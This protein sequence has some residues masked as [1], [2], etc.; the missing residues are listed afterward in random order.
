MSKISGRVSAAWI[1]FLGS[2]LLF[3]ALVAAL[4][5][6]PSTDVSK[7]PLIL[8]CAAGIKAP[9]EAAA[10]AYE[11][12]FGVPIQLQYGGSQTLQ[13]NIEL[14]QRGDLYL[15]A[16]DSYLDLARQKNLIAESIPLARM[17]LVL[18]VKQ[19]NPKR[20]GG[21]ADLMS[22]NIKLAQANPD[23]AAAGKVARE[24]LQKIGRWDELKNHTT[25]FKGTVND[26]ASDIKLGAVDAGFI[27][28][29]LLKQYPELERVNVPEFDNAHASLSVAIL[30]SSANPAAA[31]RFA[32][33]LG[34]RDKG[35]KEFERHGFK[36]VEGDAWAESPELRLMAGAMLRPALEATLADFERREGCRVTRVYNGCG[37]LVA[38]MRTGQGQRPDA[39]FACDKSFMTLVSDLFLDASDISTNQLVIMVKKGNPRGIHALKDLAQPGLKIGVGHEKQCALGALTKTTLEISGA[40]GAVLKN[41]AVQSPTGDLLVNQLRTGSLDAVIAYVSNAASAKDELECIP[42]E[43]KCALAVQ[44]FAIGRES[45]FKHLTSRLLAALQ[46][47]ASRERF[48][49]N[50]FKLPEAVK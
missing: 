32:R 23:A 16:D 18:A 24:V 27:W 33:Y 35:L 15:P 48:E 38:Q 25:V 2:V 4:L 19:G 31:L 17:Q 34:A 47:S 39:Y 43:I 30:K 7:T 46:S 8:Y 14:S 21:L 5:R 12:E 11:A 44:P 42:I 9:V 29:A 41:V 45:N 3:C 37:I 1:A 40:Y 13:A 28:D 20:I 22:P 36:P 6:Q 49:S 26:V 10:K 50:G